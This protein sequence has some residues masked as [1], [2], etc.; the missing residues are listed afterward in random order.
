MIIKKFIEAEQ[1]FDVLDNNCLKDLLKNSLEAAKGLA[2]KPEFKNVLDVLLKSKTN[3]GDAFTYRVDPE[4]VKRYNETDDVCFNLFACCRDIVIGSTK[5]VVTTKKLAAKNLSTVV[6]NNKP[7]AS[8]D[9][10]GQRRA[11]YETL[12]NA[13]IGANAAD[14]EALGLTEEANALNVKTQELYVLNVDRTNDRL[15]KLKHVATMRAEAAE[16]LRN[17]YRRVNSYLDMNDDEDVNEIA[18]TL[19]K[20][21]ADA[22]RTVLL[23]RSNEWHKGEKTNADDKNKADKLVPDNKDDKK[24][25]PEANQQQPSEPQQKQP[26]DTQNESPEKEEN[27]QRENPQKGGEAVADDGKGSDEGK[28]EL[29][30]AL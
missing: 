19:G 10:E 12:A 22:K 3:L 15:N 27:N 25:E 26:S 11:K 16:A 5:S 7:S 28:T 20:V 8:G 21:A 9:N 2:E 17:L 18:R 30:P 24:N 13:L 23:R 1:S 29:T 14:V 4:L 6:N